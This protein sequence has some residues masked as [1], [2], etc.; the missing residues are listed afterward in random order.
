MNENRQEQEEKNEYT[1]EPDEDGSEKEDVGETEEER[2]E[3]F[4]PKKVDIQ[5]TSSIMDAVIKRLR[6]HEIN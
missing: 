4:D 2:T 6:N 5:V 3:P 1:V